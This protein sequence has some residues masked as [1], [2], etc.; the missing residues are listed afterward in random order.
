MRNSIATFVLVLTLAIPLLPNASKD[1][2]PKSL[3]FTHVTVIDATGSPAQPDMTVVITGNR[4]TSVSK[5][6]KVRLPKGE[7]IIV[8]ATGKFLIPGLWDMH[9]HSLYPGRPEFFFPLLI[10]NGVTG[11]REMASVFSFAE[12][13]AIRNDIKTGKILAPRFGA[14]PGKILEGPG[15][16]ASP[17]PEF[18][19][20]STPEQA[21]EIVRS[22]KQQGADFIKVYDL[23][24][25]DVYLA[26][27]DEAKRQKIPFAGH[28]PVVLGAAEVSD[29]GQRSIEHAI[30]LPVSCSS[31]E[32]ALRKELQELLKAASSSQA[33]RVTIELKAL[34]SYDEQKAAALFARFVRKGTWQCPTLAVGRV[35]AVTENE[36]IN[37]PRMK[38]I[39]VA[40]R[41]R[42]RALYKQRY[43]VAG[44][45]ENNQVKKRFQRRL[46]IVGAMQRAGVGILAG[47]DTGFGNPFTFPGLSLHEELSLLVQSGLTPMQALQAATRNAARFLK[48]QNSLGTIEQGKIA[49]LVL[50]DADPLDDITNTRRISAV[51]ANGR[52]LSEFELKKMLA[53]VEAAASKE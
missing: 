44:A 18:V 3:I 47:T 53:D 7:S 43:G 4:I 35:A 9:V 1:N 14:V 27:V 11:V 39:P 50:L 19:V 23:L 52:Y 21:R 16:V 12:I 34:D 37:D 25:R 8:D 22:Y 38:Y 32:A 49:D 2:V 15:A 42:W 30:D 45:V 48:L 6:G 28:P 26:I 33:A 31:N 10:A 29:L 5:T 20:V 51:V 24:S 40:V 46:E 36:L 41:N 17:G 13:N